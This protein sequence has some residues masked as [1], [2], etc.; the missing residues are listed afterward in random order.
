[1]VKYLKNFYFFIW[2]SPWFPKKI[3]VLDLSMEDK[4]T[5]AN[6]EK[7]VSKTSLGKI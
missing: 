1:M 4:L 7:C 5:E 6:K 3:I 2:F